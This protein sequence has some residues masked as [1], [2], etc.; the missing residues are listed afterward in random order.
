MRFRIEQV[1]AASP[2]DVASALVDPTYLVAMG[3]LPDIGAPT[4]R[5]QEREGLIVHQELVFQFHGHLPAVVTRVIDP[6]KLSWVEYDEVDLGA[7]SATF[8]MVPSHYQKFFTCRGTWA[9]AVHGP[10][11]CQR[12]ID[13]DLRVNSP[14]P[15]VGGQV[16]RAIISGLKQRLALEP[17]VFARW[18]GNHAS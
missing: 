15:F 17:E 11:R 10:D 4:L 2:I 7:A 16:E 13:G 1:F 14:V 5:L 8:R 3:E 12:V 9:I 6:K 18:Q